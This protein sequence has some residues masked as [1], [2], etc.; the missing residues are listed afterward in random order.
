MSTLP[1]PRPASYA[2]LPWHAIKAPLLLL[3]LVVCAIAGGVWWSTGSL[4][5]ADAAY[6]AQ[7]QA[8]L[9]AQRRLQRSSTEKQLIV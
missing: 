2:H 7:T 1:S 6:R 5:R 9:A 3:A 4:M 8:N